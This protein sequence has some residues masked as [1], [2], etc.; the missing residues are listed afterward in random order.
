MCVQI[1]L[2]L[3]QIWLDANVNAFFWNWIQTTC[4]LAVWIYYFPLV[5][6]DN[7]MEGAHKLESSIFFSRANSRAAAEWD[8]RVSRRSFSVL[9]PSRIKLFRIRKVFG[10]FIRAA[11]RPKHLKKGNQHKL[12]KTHKLNGEVTR[13]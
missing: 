8:V 4:N 6:C 9:K 12:I 1:V 3:G 10:D 2:L 7:V 11:C 13:L 5:F